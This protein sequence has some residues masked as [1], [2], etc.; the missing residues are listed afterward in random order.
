MTFRPVFMN[1]EAQQQSARA[2]LQE[3]KEKLGAAAWKLS[4]R[5]IPPSTTFPPL[6]S[7]RPRRG[8]CLCAVADLQA[9]LC[10]NRGEVRAI[11]K[12]NWG[13]AKKQIKVPESEA[14]H[15]S[16]GHRPCL[17]LLRSLG[18]EVP[19]EPKETKAAAWTDIWAL[20][21]PDQGKK[22]AA[23]RAPH[24]LPLSLPLP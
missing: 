23:P 11:G 2:Q 4:K 19:R 8:C 7:R 3:N 13:W 22:V 21:S 14:S 1:F 9:G 16:Q 20:G 15:T 6:R 24:P 5:Q 17:L 10:V 12:K 18:K